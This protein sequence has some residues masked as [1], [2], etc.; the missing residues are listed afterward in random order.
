MNCKRTLNAS[1]FS[2]VLTGLLFALLFQGLAQTH[3]N[4]AGAESLVV[5]R[6]PALIR[7]E[8]VALDQPIVYNRF[9]SLNPYGMMYALE[10]DVEAVPVTADGKQ[11]WTLE[12]LSCE[13]Q[14]QLKSYARP[15]PLVLRGNVGDTLE[16]TFTNRLLPFQPDLS[17][18]CQVSAD[19]PYSKLLEPEEETAFEP[20]GETGDQ[21]QT[22]ANDWPKTR[23]ASL[24]VQGLTPVPLDGQAE[25]N[26]VC[27]GLDALPPEAVS[28][29]ESTV[30][31]RWKLERVGAFMFYSNAAPAGGEGDG[32]SLV[33]GLFGAINV[34]P[35]GSL[36]YR[37][38][39][40][41]EDLDVAWQRKNPGDTTDGSRASALDYEAVYPSADP[42]RGTEVGQPVLNFLKPLSPNEYELI[43][44]DLNA[45]IHESAPR[46]EDFIAYTDETQN[47]AAY[48]QALEDYQRAPAFREFSAIFHDELKTFYADAFRELEE[49]QLEGV[50]DGFGLNYGASGMGSILIANRKEIGPSWNCKECMYEEF[51]LQSWANGDPALLEQYKADPAN[52]YHSYLNDR[53]VFRNLHAGPKETHVF[54]LHSHQWLSASDEDK[55]SYLDSQTIAPLQGFAY[56][57][58]QGGLDNY[59]SAH[60][61]EHAQTQGSGNR[62][63]T[64]GDAIF[65]CHLYPH[66]AQGMWGLWRVHDVIE[67]G[68]RTLP[69]GQPYAGLSLRRI[70][71]GSQPRLGTDLTT[72]GAQDGTPIPAVLPL[73]SQALPPLPTYG[74]DGLAGYPFYIPGQAGHR[75]PQP[76]LDF[77]KNPDGTWRDAGLPRHVVRGGERGFTG[78]SAAET[79]ALTLEQQ[80][81]RALAL[82]DMS[83]ELES[84]NILLL[85]NAGEPAERRAMAFH[86]GTSQ[87]DVTGDERADMT[88]RVKVKAANGEITELGLTSD[89]PSLLPE[90]AASYAS[91]TSS[92][93]HFQVNKNQP[94]GGA[95]FADP[96]GDPAKKGQRDYHVSAIQLDMVVNEHGWHDPQARIN[97]LDTDV[98]TLEGKR[99][100]EA[101]P[102]FFR[103]ASGECIVF[104]HTNRTPKDLALDDFQM[105]TPTDII[106]QHI[107]LVKFDVTSSDGSANGF[108]YE[109]GTFAADAVL[110]RKCAM[111][112]YERSLG[113]SEPYPGLALCDEHDH[114]KVW[115]TLKE[116]P[117]NFQ[118]TTQRWFSDPIL[119]YQKPSTSLAS[120]LHGQETVNINGKDYATRMPFT[121]TPLSPNHAAAQSE[122][123]E[124]FTS[125][126]SSAHT[127]SSN[128]PVSAD[129][130]PMVLSETQMQVETQGETP[131]PMD[132]TMRTVFTHDHFGASSIQQ[133]GFYSALLI[134]P[135]GSI[136]CYADKRDIPENLV[137]Q[138]SSE[139]LKCPA[140]SAEMPEQAVGSRALILV[141]KDEKYHTNHRELALAIADFAL[142]YDPRLPADVDLEDW[143]NQEALPEDSLADK[144]MNQLVREGLAY[145]GNAKGLSAEDNLALQEYVSSYWLEH[146]LPVDP[147]LKPEAISK[148]HHNPYLVNY[149][150]EPIPLRI[151]KNP[152]AYS[153]DCQRGFYE[154][155]PE[156][157]NA[158]RF[159]VMLR[160]SR[161]DVSE[162]KEGAAGDMAN[163]FGSSLHGDPCTPIFEAYEGERVQLRLIQ[164]AQEVQ[165]MFNIEGLYWPRVIDYSLMG[166]PEQTVLETQDNPLALV[167][168]QE[169]G[170]SEHFEMQLPALENISGNPQT[171]DYLYHFGTADAL[172]NGAWGLLRTYNGKD[173]GDPATCL[174]NSQ[175]CANTIG[176]RLIPLPETTGS[177]EVVNR[178]QVF[179]GRLANVNVAT[180]GR[181]EFVVGET[182]PG[183]S[184]FVQYE[185]VATRH[186]LL[187]NSPLYYDKTNGLYDP[188][189]LLFLPLKS[190]WQPSEDVAWSELQ[191]YLQQTYSAKAEA[192]TLEPFV[193]RVNAGDCVVLDVYNALQTPAEVA[194]NAPMPDEPGDALMPNIVSLNVDGSKN[195]R[196]S[197][198][199]SL[200]VPMVATIKQFPGNNLAFGYNDAGEPVLP[201]Q[202]EVLRKTT[203]IFYAGRVTLEPQEEDKSN[204]S[205][206]DST[207]PVEEV[208]NTPVCVTATPYAFG[209][210][211][212][213]AFGDIIGQGVHGLMGAVI[214]EPKGAIV[215]DPNDHRPLDINKPVEVERHSLGLQA[216][217]A[218]CQADE[219]SPGQLTRF[220]EF[221]VMYQD[222]LNLHST[223]GAV[224]DCAVCDDSYDLGEKGLSYRA[225]P[226]WARLN[227]LTGSSFAA[228]SNL[229]HALFPPDFFSPVY[230]AATP[231]FVA[232][233][234]E[235]VRFRVL[236]SAGRARQR[237][238]TV[239]GYDYDDMMPEFGSPASALMSVG[240][241]MTVRLSGPD[242]NEDKVLD[243]V[244]PGCYIYRD[245]PAQFFS[246][247]VWGMFV[248]EPSDGKTLAC[249]GQ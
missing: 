11:T 163:V 172:W 44:G 104:Y 79:N 150:N 154:A 117:N 230:P 242:L 100:N 34:E 204:C 249:T 198:Q 90:D 71:P 105:K 116:D 61:D 87:L 135:F 243:G 69:D 124:S 147:P 38:Q 224:P 119:A 137:A 86:A 161:G 4:H 126:S 70:P 225:A 219:C 17:K 169:I 67:D 122:T 93:V 121:M 24:V 188:N 148:N 132:R 185:A 182:C 76:P 16:L 107:H 47:E 23:H 57:I 145:F 127:A 240:K 176:E 196:P 223:T 29:A 237:A 8:V 27:L 190:D 143:F 54:H 63:R 187:V 55:G 171:L 52:V 162:Q 195:V 39:V 210:L 110:E 220:R 50:G 10:K 159:Q 19:S 128:I 51:F 139:T 168:A 156:G 211:P 65:H 201:P 111:N 15:R 228:D 141:D 115:E 46:R 208:G 13:A 160:E 6:A 2:Q 101:E 205:D 236:Q 174:G 234:G 247:G 42:S 192:G 31:C 232:K 181:L 74:S 33:Q 125:H 106:G 215:L 12:G 136:W 96:C 129:S 178:N 66:F 200:S 30:T 72:G 180:L 138:Q 109:D 3:S 231:T 18:N 37:S 207:E 209:A 170:I 233:E 238:F 193:L 123:G 173:S 43:Y 235:E 245:G 183:G 80:L 60:G 84:A 146:G 142:L 222:G 83:G 226:F 191:S 113:R 103:A 134:E 246:G 88:I 7:A 91:L 179:N 221:V 14:W 81:Q 118:T 77:A 164:G 45:V 140:G 158:E 227:T 92:P 112:V 26:P 114:E 49:Y 157:N 85:N 244:Q 48:Q 36:W 56:D 95:P 130:E 98:A 152:S 28:E 199:L 202:T 186:D 206:S 22:A 94:K 102:F 229:N 58:Y 9:G 197:A 241:A 184:R 120:N 62:N 194:A 20:E 216:T 73:P 53:V 35:R 97:V 175:T 214:V 153:L 155:N 25:V 41:Q 189:A 248:V 40:T 64:P 217:I 167:A 32:G 151:G 21:T 166:E 99:T 78:L 213:K 5:D 108:N 177:I 203:L 149:K 133:H 82:G 89:Y 144:G 212:I 59:T 165:H 68:S 239:Y 75:A 218:Y 131:E 1:L